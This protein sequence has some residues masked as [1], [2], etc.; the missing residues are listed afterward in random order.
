[1]IPHI[2]RLSVLSRV[3]MPVRLSVRKVGPRSM[4]GLGALSPALVQAKKLGCK[5]GAE[6]TSKG[7]QC[8]EKNPAVAKKLKHAAALAR[9]KMEKRIAATTQ[10]TK[11]KKLTPQR[12]FELLRA[13]RARVAAKKA[14]STAPSESI[15]VGNIRVAPIPIDPGKDV[16][17][18]TANE[19]SLVTTEA[20][21]EGGLGLG[22]LLA[23]AVG[24]VA[25]GGIA[26]L[27]LRKKGGA[28]ASSPRRSSAK[29]STR[30]STAPI[31]SARSTLRSGTAVLPNK[32]GSTKA[33]RW[34]LYSTQSGNYLLTTKSHASGPVPIEIDDVTHGSAKRLGQVTAPWPRY[35]S[36]ADDLVQRLLMR[37]N[38][39]KRGPIELELARFFYKRGVAVRK[40]RGY[41]PEAAYSAWRQ[42][43]KDGRDL[44]SEFRR[45]RKVTATKA[46]KEAKGFFESGLFPPRSK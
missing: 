31:S 30:S 24:V 9:K 46:T 18:V 16:A 2:Q 22:A 36:Q 12:A 15:K 26:Y 35:A 20:E 33:G 29:R 14:Q 27:L 39:S 6:Y 37:A 19:E 10:T 17:V 43:L 42:A 40:R 4:T 25:V 28:P 13:G 34:R 7:W 8:R 45:A 23:G 1:M 21:D 3:A 38:A 5:Q 44:L 11:A 41:R 32:Y